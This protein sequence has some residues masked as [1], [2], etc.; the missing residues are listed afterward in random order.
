MFNDNLH[1]QGLPLATKADKAEYLK[2][3]IDLFS[4]NLTSTDTVWFGEWILF[5][6]L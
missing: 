2:E 6:P 5:T 3:D 4:W 1:T